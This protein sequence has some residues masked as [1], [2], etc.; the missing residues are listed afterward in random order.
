MER[1]FKVSVSWEIEVT[2]VDEEDAYFK[3]LD[4]LDRQILDAV[5]SYD[6]ESVFN[7]DVKEID[8]A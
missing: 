8:R 1:K 6:Y 5:R 3:A 2:A 4:E 7:I